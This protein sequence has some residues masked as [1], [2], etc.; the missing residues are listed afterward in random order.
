[1][2]MG[3]MA[4]TRV[5]VLHVPF[6]FKGRWKLCQENQNVLV[7]ILVVLNLPMAGIV[8]SML[9]RWQGNITEII[10]PTSIYTIPQGGKD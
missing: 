10:E 1:M 8:K 4:I 5:G 2:R 7:A 6:L 3:N 9:R